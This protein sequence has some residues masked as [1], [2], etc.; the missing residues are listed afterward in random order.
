MI[1]HPE[2]AEGEGLLL[3]PC[4]GVHMHWMTYPLD[5]AFLDGEGRIV[6]LYHGLRPWRFSKTH[7]D[8]TCAIEFPAGTLENTGTVVGN[9]L[10][11]SADQR[12][13]A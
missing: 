4:Q 9:R 11:W 12:M 8:A 2:P 3:N 10:S 13:A 6:A 1:G 7:K 5:I